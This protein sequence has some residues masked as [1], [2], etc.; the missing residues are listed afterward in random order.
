MSGPCND[1]ASPSMLALEAALAENRYQIRRAQEMARK[2][3]RLRETGGLTSCGVQRVL[4]VFCLSAWQVDIALAVAQQLTTFSKGHARYPTKALIHELFVNADLDDLLN[5]YN[6]DN[7]AWKRATTFAR[8]ALLEHEVWHQ[9]KKQNITHGI[10]PS[11]ASVFSLFERYGHED[12]FTG[13]SRKRSLNKFVSR[14][15]VRWQVRRGK[16]PE[17]DQLD[18]ETLRQKAGFFGDYEVPKA[19]PFF[20][21]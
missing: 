14:W 12:S 18:A 2:E 13:T 4:A 15:C 20:E 6:E 21:P 3:A 11:F 7:A 5:M 1:G 19:G 8:K 10:A 17:A 16:L 9:V